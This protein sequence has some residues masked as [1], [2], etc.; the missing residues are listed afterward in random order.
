MRDE[1]E[2]REASPSK[3]V[4]LS[5]EL[6]RAIGAQATEDL[7]R[8]HIECASEF[9]SWDTEDGKIHAPVLLVKEC[10]GGC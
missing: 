7:L 1:E 4:L 10:P 5:W 3:T 9:S 6:Q 2:N 8:K